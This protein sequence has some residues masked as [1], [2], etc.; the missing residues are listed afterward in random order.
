MLEFSAHLPPITISVD[1]NDPDV[2]DYVTHLQPTDGTTTP[3]T[4]GGRSCRENAIPSEDL[5]FYFG[6]DDSV[7]Y[8]L[9]D[10]LTASDGAADD[11]FGYSV[12][13]DGDRVVVGAYFDDTSPSSAYIYE[14][15]SGSGTWAETKLTASDGAASDWFGYSVAIVF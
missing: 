7:V 5:Y 15:D 3:A 10:K 8:Q 11:E 14:Y 6:V 1:L 12:A 4:I 2:E 9:I 13:I